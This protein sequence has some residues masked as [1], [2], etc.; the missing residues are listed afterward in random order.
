MPSTC[1]SSCAYDFLK[2]EATSIAEFKLDE[3]SSTACQPAVSKRLV[4]SSEV[5][6]PAAYNQQLGEYLSEVDR[7]TFGLAVSNRVRVPLFVVEDQ[8]D[9]A[10]TTELEGL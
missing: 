1:I 6:V 8:D 4:V 2:A 9:F 7:V 3:P 5:L 10:R